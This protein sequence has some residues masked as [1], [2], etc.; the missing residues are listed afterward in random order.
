MRAYSQYLDGVQRREHTAAIAS[1]PRGRTVAGL[2][3][4]YNQ[5]IDLGG[6]VFEE[7]APGSVPTSEHLRLCWQH[8]EPIGKIVQMKQTQD[9]V[10]IE[11]KLSQTRQAEEALELLNDEV[12][13]NL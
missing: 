11:G 6:G 5:R 4:P 3:V 8:S 12:I 9:G 10:E 13:R 7:F 1:A 2:G